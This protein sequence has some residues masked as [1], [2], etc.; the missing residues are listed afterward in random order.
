M[1]R[2]KN[3]APKKRRLTLDGENDHSS[4]QQEAI[5]TLL[6]TPTDVVEAAAAEATRSKSDSWKEISVS[7]NNKVPEWLKGLGTSR[8]VEDS[9]FEALKLLHETIKRKVDNNNTWSSW[10]GSTEDPRK[11]AFGFL[12]DTLGFQGKTREFLDI[13]TPWRDNQ[14]TKNVSKED[15]EERLRNNRAMVMLEDLPD[16]VK[17]AIE[18]V[19]QLFSEAIPKE[20]QPILKYSNLIAAQPNLHCG[21]TLLPIHVDHPRKD[22]FGI[23]IITI[24][25]ARSGT[26][27]LIKAARE[28]A[29]KM[30]VPERHAYML[31]DKARDSCAHGVLAID[32]DGLRESLNL[33]FGLHD[34]AMP[35]LPLILT[36]RVLKYWEQTTPQ[37]TEKH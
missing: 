3:R 9:H 12:H 33:R 19:C 14:D 2:T 30:Q 7:D 28:A 8:K 24:G 34:F 6:E 5:K 25:I 22:G 16:S 20:L 1:G 10:S 35:G 15:E 13:T 18:H 26:I 27:L 21:R 4:S 37:E 29:M 23:V 11:R 17:A 36:Q 32:D 31:S